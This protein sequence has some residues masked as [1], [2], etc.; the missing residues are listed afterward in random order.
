[1]PK[2]LNPAPPGNWW[3]ISWNPMTGCEHG[4]EICS[5]PNICWARAMAK[6]FKQD[7]KPA[8]HPERFDVRF[9]RLEPSNIFV[10]D[11]GD[12]FGER[13]PYE[14]IESILWICEENQQHKF[15]FLTKN[16]ER[17]NRYV[18]PL[19]CWIGTSITKPSELFR[20]EQLHDF[21]HGREKYFVSFEPLLEKIGYDDLIKYKWIN[22]QWVI[23]GGF[24]GR[25]KLSNPDCHPAIY[26]LYLR[27]FFEDIK[28]PVFIKDNLGWKKP[29][30]QF[31]EGLNL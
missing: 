31:P 20:I 25:Q 12:L 1:M 5:C 18:F 3:D 10:C 27:H 28:I 19:N 6:R 11:M 15:L 4:P 17:Y 14:W 22:I 8:I 30:K 9:D 7:F 24:S 23:I 2:Y 29:L 26:A 16:P 13:V 21:C